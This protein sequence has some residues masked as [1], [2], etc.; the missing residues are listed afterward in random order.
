MGE[1]SEARQHQEGHHVQN[2]VA[3]IAWDCWWMR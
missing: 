3:R 1:G 2:L